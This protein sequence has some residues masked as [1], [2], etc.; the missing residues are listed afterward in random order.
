MTIIDPARIVVEDGYPLISDGVQTAA[1]FTGS[2]DGLAQ[3]RCAGTYR[4]SEASICDV[5]VNMSHGTQKRVSIASFLLNDKRCVEE[6]I[7]AVDRRYSTIAAVHSPLWE[8]PQDNTV[9]QICQKEE[10]QL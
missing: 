5:L 7:A 6:P 1:P 2:T 8:L 3:P 10:F 4:D 9:Y